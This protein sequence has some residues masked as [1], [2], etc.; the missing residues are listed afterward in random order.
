MGYVG[1][2]CIANT[3]F[4]SSNLDAA[5]TLSFAG[6]QERR[7]SKSQPGKDR[8]AST[9]GSHSQ[10]LSTKG[11]EVDISAEKDAPDKHRQSS[12]VAKEIRMPV[13]QE[14]LCN[15]PESGDELL[16]ESST[17]GLVGMFLQAGR[18]PMGVPGRQGH[19][20]GHQEASKRETEAG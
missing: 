5:S 20:N 15:Y 17:E 8:Q 10:G 9:E 12:Q 3:V 14:G 13:D 1:A 19:G 4:S 7:D 6:A 11:A 2:P 18:E 16:I